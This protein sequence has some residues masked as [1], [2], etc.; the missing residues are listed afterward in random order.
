MRT[1]NNSATLKFSGGGGG[2]LSV[3]N[4]GKEGQKEKCPSSTGMAR[5]VNKEN[6]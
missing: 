6:G 3:L 1:M 4:R 2:S 5:E